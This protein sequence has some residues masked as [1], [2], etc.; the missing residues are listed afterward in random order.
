MKNNTLKRGAPKRGLA[1]HPAVIAA[2]IGY[3]DMVAGRAFD[4]WRFTD[5]I[6]QCNYEI[7]RLWA[8]NI[9][10][11]GINPPIWP[12]G[13]NI[14]SIVQAMIKQSFLLVGDCQPRK[15]GAK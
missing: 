15:S 9:K 13:K 3:S 11:A 14:P 1:A 12:K 4:V 10:T 8:L 7:G 5:Q 2:Q 6:G